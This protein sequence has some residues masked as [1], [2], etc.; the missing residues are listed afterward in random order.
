MIGVSFHQIWMD[1]ENEEVEVSATCVDE[2]NS[3]KNSLKESIVQRR[4][5]PSTYYFV[6]RIKKKNTRHA[7]NIPKK[8]CST[9]HQCRID[10]R[11]I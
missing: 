7:S 4:Y 8:V 2:K 6:K 10:D 9:R 11:F 5:V 3:S 1:K